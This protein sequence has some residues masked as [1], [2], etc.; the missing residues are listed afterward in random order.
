MNM[1]GTNRTPE[2]VL[3]IARELQI[4][5]FYL[6]DRISEM[7]LNILCEEWVSMYYKLE[8]AQ[9]EIEALKNKL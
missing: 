4:R 6:T 9:A 3:E 5:A 2:Q 8:T 7:K 1:L